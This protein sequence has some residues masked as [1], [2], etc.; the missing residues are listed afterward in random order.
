M[1]VGSDWCMNGHNPLVHH[2]VPLLIECSRCVMISLLP[3]RTLQTWRR[4]SRI[5]RTQWKLHRHDWKWERVD[6]MWSC[7]E[8]QHNT[9][10]WNYTVVP[11]LIVQLIDRHSQQCDPKSVLPSTAWLGRFTR[12]HAPLTH[13]CRNWMMQ[14]MLWRIYRTTV[15]LWRKKYPWKRMPSSLR[16]TNA[17][18]TEH[19][20][21]AP[22]NCRVTSEEGRDRCTGI[23]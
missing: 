20:T 16:K 6:Q 15:W 18:H 23:L 8:T 14:R 3:R 4:Q 21:L 13:W 5:R 7:A 10:K 17:S 12:L 2:L 19:G 1:E 22:S 9:S 11:N